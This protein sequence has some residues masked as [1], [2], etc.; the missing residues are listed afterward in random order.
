M[1][2]QKAGGGSR[3]DRD[4][5][6]LLL[7]H[8]VHGRSAVV[9]FTDLVVHTGVEKNTLGGRGLASVDVRRNADIAIPLDRGLASHDGSLVD[10]TFYCVL[11]TQP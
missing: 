11:V 2:F 6:L 10:L 9:H 3:G 7:L 5:A 1:P 8:P 4:A